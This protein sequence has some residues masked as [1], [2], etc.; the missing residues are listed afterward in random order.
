MINLPM[1]E[2]IAQ[3]VTQQKRAAP[4]ELVDIA[5]Y[6]AA[7]P[8]ATDLLEADE[9]LW[10][11]F[12]QFDVIAPGYTLPAIELALLRAT[13][14]DGHW[15]EDTTADQFLADLRQAILHPQAGI[16]TLPV[17]GEPFIIFA[18]YSEQDKNPKSTQSCGLRREIA[19]P[20]S[21]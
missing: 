1:D 20:K 15:P 5:N 2:L 13:R 10:G 17:S 14:L 19:N 12:W 9:P 11:S 21:F 8:F 4:A 7:A 18:V 3:L 6:V 16:W